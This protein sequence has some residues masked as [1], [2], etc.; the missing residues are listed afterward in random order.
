MAHLKVINNTSASIEEKFVIN[1][2]LGNA[3]Y[4]GPQGEPGPQG[5]PGPEG[6]Q[7]EA[8]PAGPRGAAGPKGDKGDTG[9]Q[10]VP[11]PQGPQG[12]QGVPGPQ[13]IQ[14]EKGDSYTL[15]EDDKT[16]IAAIVLSSIPSAEEVEV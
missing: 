16:D 3:T 8:G 5:I 10:G 14:G 9:A 12:P 1:S 7:G 2:Q 13:G 4:R 15:T 11:G 6:K